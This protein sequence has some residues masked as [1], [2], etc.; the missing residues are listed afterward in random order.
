MKTT[1]P[2]YIN[3]LRMN[4]ATRLLTQTDLPI[5]QIAS[6]LGFGSIRNFNRV[7]LE[8]LGTSPKA[9]R[10]GTDNEK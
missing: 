4:D 6:E 1:I 10:S 2:Q 7:F 9:Y 8:H 3:S 5:T